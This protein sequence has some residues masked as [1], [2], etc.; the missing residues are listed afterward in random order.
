MDRER[1]L[2]Y[3]VAILAAILEVMTF[4]AFYQQAQLPERTAAIRE[5]RACQTQLARSWARCE[6]RHVCDPGI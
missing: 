5:V 4:F 3:T 6:A 1:K 2:L